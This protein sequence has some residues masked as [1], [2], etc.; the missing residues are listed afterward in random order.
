MAKMNT[1]GQKHSATIVRPR[2]NGQ[3]TVGSNNNGQKEPGNVGHQSPRPPLTQP[4]S[5]PKKR[6]GPDGKIT[7]INS[8]DLPIP[9]KTVPE[10]Q[11]AVES[12][13]ESIEEQRTTLAQKEQDLEKRERELSEM[14][15]KVEAEKKR[16]V[17][18]K[19]ELEQHERALSERDAELEAR[20]QQKNAESEYEGEKQFASSLHGSQMEGVRDL[21]RRIADICNQC[22][23]ENLI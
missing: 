14:E 13:Q 15:K 3:K 6:T 19:R 5:K 8:G 11:R 12:Q 20:E 4:A 10:R 16:L 2:P 22:Q 1:Y 7:G 23:D 18:L 21:I 9:E 17:S